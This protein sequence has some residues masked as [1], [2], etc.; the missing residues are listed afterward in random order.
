MSNGAAR[1]PSGKQTGKEGRA[2]RC[3]D[4]ETPSRQG[5]KRLKRTTNQPMNGMENKEK[6]EKRSNKTKNR[7]HKAGEFE[8]FHLTD[9][10]RR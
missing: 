6:G 9:G 2:K 4:K 1:S 3:K 5:Q 8:A 7:A 10:A